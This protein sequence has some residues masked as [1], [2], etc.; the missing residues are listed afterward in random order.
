[1]V[2]VYGV[3]AYFERC[4]RS[5]FEQTYV[6]LEYVF[7][8]DCSP[9]QSIGVLKSV[10]KDYPKREQ[11]V[12]IIH[13][14]KNRG[15]AA[16][17]NTC[18]DSASGEFVCFVDADD[19]LER[20][21]IQILVSKQIESNADLV[22]GRTCEHKA[23]GVEDVHYPNLKEEKIILL[24]LEGHCFPLH[25]TIIRKTLF[26]EN[27]IRCLEGFNMAED[28][29]MVCLLSYYAN[30]ILSCDKLVY[31]YDKK[32][33]NSVMHETQDINKVL[34]NV[35]ENLQ[36]KLSIMDFFSD[37]E[38]EYFDKAVG[39][40]V[41]MLRIVLKQ[42]LK[43]R[44]RQIFYEIINLIDDNP[45]IARK[46]QWRYSGFKAF[47]LHNYALS[48]TDYQLHRIINLVLIKKES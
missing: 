2:P 14:E 9:D 6:D 48:L 22:L 41:H 39:M 27:A 34:R 21:A 10:M 4:C 17:R 46:M 26:D 45:A 35:Y 33:P 20:E 43:R 19:W 44:N 36:N 29:R 8:N 31:H 16:A 30:K 25:G 12:K 18:L 23:D 11:C 47:L 7:V 37:K 42:S 13:H 40:A 15:V 5:L 38:E 3:E 1:M 32:N 28:V 24:N